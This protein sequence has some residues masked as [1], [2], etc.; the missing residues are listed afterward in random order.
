MKNLLN[1]AGRNSNA[2]GNPALTINAGFSATEPPLP[3]GMMMIGRDFE[4]ATVLHLAHAYE[5]L[6]N[7]SPT[8]SAM[9]TRLHSA[10]MSS[11]AQKPR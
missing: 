5:R 3:I 1:L 4:D 7:S 2:T 6:R 10:M 9:E 11:S 8:Y